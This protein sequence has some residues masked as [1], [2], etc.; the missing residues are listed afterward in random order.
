[1]VFGLVVLC[2]LT[3]CRTY[4]L[5]AVM[6]ASTITILSHPA[7]RKSASSYM[8]L[9]QTYTTQCKKQTKLF[10]LET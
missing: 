9:E 2:I 7:V 6:S 4:L 5:L 3:L 1:V 8:T 10:T